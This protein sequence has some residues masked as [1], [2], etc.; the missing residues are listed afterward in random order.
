MVFMWIDERGSEVLDPA[1]C[2]RLLAL[3]AKQGLHGHIGIASDGAPLVLPVNYAADGSDVVIRIGEGLF[4]RVEG[5]RLIALQVDG[6]DAGRA[7][8]VLVRGLAIED[9]GDHGGHLPEHFP[10]PA[11]TEPGHRIVR[12]RTDVV[13]GRRL[14]AASAPPPGAGRPTA[15]PTPVRASVG[16]RTGP[17][18]RVDG[19]SRWG[20]LVRTWGAHSVSGSNCAE[21]NPSGQGLRSGRRD[22]CVGTADRRPEL[23]Q[24]W[25]ASS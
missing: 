19:R 14:A 21:R 8:S 5:A 15:R 3:G 7:W 23:P 16:D 11:V 12:I 18:G 9:D 4:E 22:R 13:T 10:Q 1:E 2:H 25:P 20:G 17:G 6:V 24:R